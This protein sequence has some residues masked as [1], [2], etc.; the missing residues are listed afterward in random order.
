MKKVQNFV[1]KPTQLALIKIIAP[2]PLLIY[3]SKKV[4]CDMQR[5]CNREVP[6]FHDCADDHFTKPLSYK[7]TH[8]S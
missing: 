3:L 6:S 7:G 5:C 4:F 2:I 8:R 1:H